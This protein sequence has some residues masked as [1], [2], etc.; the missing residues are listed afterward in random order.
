MTTDRIQDSGFG[1]QGAARPSFPRKRAPRVPRRIPRLAP[2]VVALA[3]L[4]AAGC[5]RPGAEAATPAPSYSEIS[6]LGGTTPTIAAAP[7]DGGA[8]VAWVAIQN[9]E[10][11]VLVARRGP[12]GVV[13][14]PVRV[15]DVAGDA[16]P[17]AQAPAQVATGPDGEVY[18]VWQSTFDVEYLDFGGSNVRFSRSSDGGQTWSPAVTVNDN[19]ASEPARNTFHNIDVAQDGTIYV[20]WIDARVRDGYRGKVF[21]E[22]GETADP[23]T[24][25]GT[26]I[27]IARSTDGGQTFSPSVVLETNSCPCC[28]TSTAVALDGTVYV[29]YRKVF[30]GNIRDIV[31]ARST[32][33]GQ[34]FS[35]P[36]RVHDDEWHI[37]G[38]PHAGASL[39]VD[40]QGRLHVAW[41]TGAEG[42][43]GAYYTVSSDQA[44][45]FAEP[46]RLTPEGPVPTS[47]AA[48][49][50]DEAGNVWVA[51]EALDGE[52]RTVALARVDEDG[53]LH[54]IDLDSP[55]GAMPALAADRDGLLLTWQEGETVRIASVAR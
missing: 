10:S 14:T 43:P 30:D 4:G 37:E 38:C 35:E 32:D 31:V 18:A 29:S 5:D 50:A 27:R 55:T 19:P 20:S 8:F 15:N 33:G 12:D 6:G 54:R 51:W 44:H 2:G 28:R 46:T 26:E 34:T 52:T 1:I 11:N 23:A 42:A 48:V 22:T 53:E 41:F 13:T 3:V 47:L 45:T 24:E 49:A 25:P 39:A 9:G 17:H 36:V 16:A 40:G 21:R 7:G